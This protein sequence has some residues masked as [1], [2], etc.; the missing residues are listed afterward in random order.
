M[1]E[2]DIGEPTAR[3]DRECQLFTQGIHGEVAPPPRSLTAG[4][5]AVN[6]ARVD[7]PAT[8]LYS[9]HPG[10]VATAILSVMVPLLNEEPSIEHVGPGGVAGSKRYSEAVRDRT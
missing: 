6:A 9:L 8:G 3:N 7:G 5:P 1:Q 10:V 2:S 4:S